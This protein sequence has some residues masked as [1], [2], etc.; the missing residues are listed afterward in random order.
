MKITANKLN[1]NTLPRSNCINLHKSIKSKLSI[2]L[3][4][5]LIFIL[6]PFIYP[7]AS[8]LNKI[9]SDK[10]RSLIARQQLQFIGG[11]LL[12]LKTPQGEKIEA[13]HISA[14]VF[15]AKIE[16]YFD[17][18]EKKT[19]S[20]SVQKFLILKPEYGTPYEG[21][22]PNPHLPW[23]NINPEA[24][25]FMRHL[26]VL[27][28]TQGTFIHHKNR[29]LNLLSFGSPL[30]VNGENNLASDREKNI[31]PTVILC[32]GQG[33]NVFC[34]KSLVA[35]LLSKGL[36]VM[37]FNYRGHG[38]SEGSPSATKTYEDVKTCFR[39]LKKHKNMKP[40]NCIAY[41]YCLGSAPATNLAAKYGT[42]LI[43]DRGFG[44]YEDVAGH[45]YPKISKIIKK[46]LP[47]V[48]KYDNLVNLPRVHGHIAIHMGMEDKVIPQSQIEK[49]LNHLPSR[50]QE[51]IK[52]LIVS[53]A[54]HNI[55]LTNRPTA[56]TQLDHFLLQTG[57][58]N[59]IFTASTA[60]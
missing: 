38:E 43:I 57:L 36:D 24:R 9:F 27:N 37:L 31:N 29:R 16:T 59:N 20:G 52:N 7:S 28:V 39:Y 30:P 50:S 26:A 33:A 42:N 56:N 55:V 46:V 48:V 8:I 44:L 40:K 15:K 60:K 22:P 45:V 41:G 49:L 21:E 13:M 4:E 14:H 18:I 23:R 53:D 35:A 3:K 47:K 54:D 5:F 2:I 32:P 12:K 34:H 58:Y 51:Q 6:M 25:E 17:I 1:L 11:E 19:A 10:K